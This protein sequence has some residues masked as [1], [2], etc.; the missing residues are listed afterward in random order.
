MKL[1]QAFTYQQADQVLETYLQHFPDEINRQ[2]EFSAYLKRNQGL[3][4]IDR[5]NF[6]GHIT[7]SVFLY[8]PGEKA[9]LLLHHKTLN[10][11]LQP[12]GHV[13]ESD[14][15][16]VSAA[17]RELTEET[18]IL[19]EHFRLVEHK[20]GSIL[21]VDID[22]HIIPEN[23]KKNE[24]LHYH[25][26]I[27]FACI[28]THPKPILVNEEESIGSQFLPLTQLAEHTDLSIVVDKLNLLILSQDR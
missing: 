20:D 17:L 21:P 18:G 6:D 9:L 26:D 2:Q 27:R 13:D 19:A 4:R 28:Y 5:K 3:A 15:D 12:G 7:A 25:H 23:P 1:N 11:W 16:I 14:P 8:H 10:K 22:S 24:A